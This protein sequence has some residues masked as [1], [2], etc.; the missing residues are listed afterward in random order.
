LSPSNFLA[1]HIQI[2]SQWNWSTLCFKYEVRRVHSWGR[3]VWILVLIGVLLNARPS[4]HGCA[5]FY[6]LSPLLY[7]LIASSELYSLLTGSCPSPQASHHAFSSVQPAL[8]S[9]HLFL[10][11]RC[12]ENRSSLIVNNPWNL[13]TCKRKLRLLSIPTSREN[14]G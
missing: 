6:R 1:I 13:E 5:W 14:Y 10:I 11:F 7:V 8:G 2:L 9:D 4:L 3:G 12:L